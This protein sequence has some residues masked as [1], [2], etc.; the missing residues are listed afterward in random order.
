MG[1]NQDDWLQAMIIGLILILYIMTIFNIHLENS[2]KIVT[3]GYN[4]DGDKR[5][6]IG[7]KQCDIICDNINITNDIDDNYITF[8]GHGNCMVTYNQSTMRLNIL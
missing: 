6:Y 1:E 4:I 2:M 3:E 8:H 7:D 5:I